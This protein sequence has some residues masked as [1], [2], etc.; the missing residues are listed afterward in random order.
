MEQA[1]G[2]G[3]VKR[4]FLRVNAGQG[5]PVLN[6]GRVI[7]S[8]LVELKQVG[9]DRVIFKMSGDDVRIRIIRRMLHRTHVVN[10]DLLG[11]HDHAAR[12]LARGA[13]Y[14]RAARG[15]AVLLRTRTLDAALVHV[16]FDIAVGGLFRHRADRTRAEHMVVSENLACVVVDAR[17]V[18]AREIQVDIR[19]LIA[20]EAEEGF[21]RD[22]KALLGQR[23]AA[24]RHTLS[25]RSTPQEYSSCHS[26]YLSSGQVMRRERVYLGDI[27]HKRCER[28]ADRPARADQI[29]VRERLGHK[30]LR[31]D[32]HDRVAVANDGVQLAVEPRLHQL[33]SGSP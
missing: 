28:R 27:R 33:G 22:V 14:A 11:Y 32:V 18:L 29:A 23:L 12:V 9:V 8:Q 30:L 15:E 4:D 31:D 1:H 24:G 7:V 25:G 26:T 17:L 10:F 21:E 3:I 19:H 16:F 5:F 20:L 2:V 6:H 13:A